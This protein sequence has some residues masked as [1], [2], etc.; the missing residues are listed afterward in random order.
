[1]I[2]Q[3][4]IKKFKFEELSEAFDQIRKYEKTGILIDG[5][6]RNMSESFARENKQEDFKFHK[7][8]CEA[9]LFEMARRYVSGLK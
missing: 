2:L 5:I 1:M 9:F 7:L 8:T 6:V 3:D 4:E